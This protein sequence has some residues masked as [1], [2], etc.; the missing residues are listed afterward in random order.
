MMCSGKDELQSRALWEGKGV[1][2]R[3][4]LMDKLQ[5][6]LPPSIML[7]PHR[8]LYF[9]FIRI[10]WSILMYFLDYTH[11][12]IKQSNTKNINVLIIIQKVK[13]TMCL[14]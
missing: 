9:Q 2:S 6:F 3:G 5:E 14:Y 4:L 7:P 12:L 1:R 10:K 11:Y 13:K 8:Y